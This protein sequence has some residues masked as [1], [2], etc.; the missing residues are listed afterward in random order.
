MREQ[1]YIP[2]AIHGAPRSGT[3]WIGEVINSSPNTIYKFQPL[4]SYA[5]KDFLTPAST[6]QDIQEFFYRLAGCKDKFTNRTN[7]RDAGKLPTFEKRKIS[8]V[9]YKEVRHHNILNNMMRRTDEL[10]LVAIIR[11][12]MS[13]LNSW[14]NAGREFREDL[15]WNILE[16][17]RYA[18]KKNMNK[19]EEFNGFEKWKELGNLILQLEQQY[20]DRIYL[21]Q[22]SKFLANTVQETKNL[23][24]F[25]DLEYTMQTEKFITDST[26]TQD[27]DPYSV[28]RSAQTDDAWKSLLAAEIISEIEADIKDT[29]LEIFL[30]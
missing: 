19:P 14:L 26:N 28:Y 22:Y 25:L 29:A 7:Q 27:D 15:G 8:H 13:V 24:Q 21:I 9:A 16:E 20:P 12:P 17:W 1:K 5:H 18:L 30:D 6:K 10:K 3:T 23:F 11:N 2:V 4:F